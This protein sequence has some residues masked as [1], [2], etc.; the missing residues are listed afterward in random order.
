MERLT[1]LHQLTGIPT[2]PIWQWGLIQCIA[3]GLV[4]LQSGQ[5]EEGQKLISIAES[6]RDVKQDYKFNQ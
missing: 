1:F 4:L 3:T 2:I 5:K 6:W